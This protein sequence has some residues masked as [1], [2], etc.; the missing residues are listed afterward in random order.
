MTKNH[1]R[2]GKQNEVKEERTGV[3]RNLFYTTEFSSLSPPPHHHRFPPFGVSLLLR[4]FLFSFFAEDGTGGGG[5]GDFSVE[6]FELERKSGGPN[7]R[8]ARKPL[9]LLFIIR[10]HNIIDYRQLLHSEIAGAFCGLRMPHIQQMA[11]CY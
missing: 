1:Q 2:R 6:K 9:T 11:S 4:Y 8:A 10:R 7:G 5:G 3:Y